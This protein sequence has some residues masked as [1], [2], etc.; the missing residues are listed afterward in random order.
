MNKFILVV[1]ASIF[2]IL[3]LVAQAYGENT[4]KVV[5]THYYEGNP[6]KE[7]VFYNDEGKEIAREYYHIEGRSSGVKGRIPDGII[8]EYFQDGTV[9][10][11]ALYK[12]N[13]MLNEAEFYDNGAKLSVTVNQWNGRAL[14]KMAEVIYYPNGNKKQEVVMDG[15]GNGISKLY[16]DTGELY[17]QVPLVDG[18]REGQVKKYFKSGKLQF[19][20]TM[21]NGELIGGKE[22]DSSGKLIN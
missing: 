12:T 14:E 3:P 6:K 17:E 2:C 19:S 21:K 4:R 13:L 11:K 5:A 9:K 16:Y 1:F 10:S 8:M 18:M 7:M 15:G 20:G 22:Y